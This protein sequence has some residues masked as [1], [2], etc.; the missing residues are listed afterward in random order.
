MIEYANNWYTG[1][2]SKESTFYLILRVARSVNILN[3]CCCII[4]WTVSRP[5][6]C[7]HDNNN[8]RFGTEGVTD[9]DERERNQFLSESRWKDFPQNR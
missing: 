5:T 9:T 8:G 3:L 4:S 6:Y 7:F 2:E 1:Y